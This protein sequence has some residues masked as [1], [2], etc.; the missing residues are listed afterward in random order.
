MEHLYHPAGN[1]D[2]ESLLFILGEKILPVVGFYLGPYL[3]ASGYPGELGIEAILYEAI[4]KW[5]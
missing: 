3:V 5:S 2:V 4:R 1:P